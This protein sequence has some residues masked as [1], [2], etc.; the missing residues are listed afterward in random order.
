LVVE[1]P[2]FGLEII[3]QP[4]MVVKVGGEFL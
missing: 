4:A 2:E 3:Q 1:T